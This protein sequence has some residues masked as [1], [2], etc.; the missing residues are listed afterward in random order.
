MWAG[1]KS[2]PPGKYP[3]SSATHPDSLI[4]S[5]SGSI[6]LGFIPNRIQR[7]Y[8]QKFKKNLQLENKFDIVL[9]KNCNLLIPRPP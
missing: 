8:N 3:Q 7:F 9:I 1:K 2:T 6:I 5:G 4:D